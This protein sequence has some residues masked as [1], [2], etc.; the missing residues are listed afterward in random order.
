MTITEASYMENTVLKT[1]S[2]WIR[3]GGRRNTWESMSARPSLCSKITPYVMAGLGVADVK[4]SWADSSTNFA[5][6]CS[7]IVLYDESWHLG[8][9]GIVAIFLF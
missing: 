6:Y 2:T 5:S 8:V 7:S 9:L 1:H 4:V 3:P